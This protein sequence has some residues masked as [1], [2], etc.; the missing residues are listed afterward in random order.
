MKRLT[1]SIVTS[2]HSRTCKNA[3]ADPHPPWH[4]LYTFFE[5]SRYG[6]IYEGQGMIFEPLK[7][8]IKGNTYV[9]TL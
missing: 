2:I 8:H 6:I 5:I 7:H 4:F 9:P 3:E 1:T